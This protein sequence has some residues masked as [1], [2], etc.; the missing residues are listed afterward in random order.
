MKNLIKLNL[1]LIRHFFLLSGNQSVLSNIWPFFKLLAPMFIGYVTFGQILELN[2]QKVQY[3][4]WVFSGAS[5]WLLIGSSIN[6]GLILFSNHNRRM[7]FFHPR[8]SV[9]LIVFANL[10]PNFLLSFILLI[11]NLEYSQLFYNKQG[12]IIAIL[13]VLLLHLFLILTSIAIAIIFGAL[14]AL[15]KDFRIFSQF[16]SQYL[17]LASP[18]FYANNTPNSALEKI[19]FHLNPITPILEIHRSIIFHSKL[20]LS[21]IQVCSVISL[22]IIGLFVFLKSDSVVSRLLWCTRRITNN[23]HEIEEENL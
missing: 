6:T 5:I 8:I 7:K 20:Q 10:A 23:Y 12:Y 1:N 19:M 15:M 13:L 17:L 11:Y 16:V 14:T 3:S 22:S 4:N 18:I 21:T 2:V 9:K